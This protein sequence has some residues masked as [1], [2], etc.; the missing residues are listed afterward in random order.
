VAPSAGQ[1]SLVEKKKVTV[2]VGL[3][4]PFRW[5]V[6]ETE[7]PAV[8]VVDESVVVSAGVAEETMTC[9]FVAPLSE[10]ALLLLSPE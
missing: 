3:N 2:P 8:I 7:P 1:E 5:A 4:P 6:S 10:T 9:S